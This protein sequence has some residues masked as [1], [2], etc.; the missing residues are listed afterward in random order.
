[1]YFVIERHLCYIYLEDRYKNVCA[2]H[3]DI[4][5]KASYKKFEIKSW[6]ILIFVF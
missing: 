5:R 2:F 3:L 6:N 4:L 1:M